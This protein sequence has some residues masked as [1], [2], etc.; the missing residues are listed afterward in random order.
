[1]NRLFCIALCL[2]VHAK[3]QSTLSAD[4]LK[5]LKFREIGPANMGGR[6]DDFA[7]VESN[8]NIVY[9]ATASGGLWKTVNSGI[10]WKPIFDDQPVSTIGDVTVSQSEPDV[11]SVGT[12]GGHNR[13]S[14]SWG[15]GVY[16]SGDGRKLW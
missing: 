1:M 10:S 15:N 8:T 2:P 7:V 5:N 11:V 4:L 13:H 16:K 6:V 3:T 14:A 12:G 9:A